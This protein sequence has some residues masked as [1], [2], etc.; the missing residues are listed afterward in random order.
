MGG[1]ETLPSKATRGAG[2]LRLSTGAA[3]HTATHDAAARPISP[4]LPS[5]LRGPRASRGLKPTPRNS[6]AALKRKAEEVL[7]APPGW[8][9]R[10]QREQ[11]PQRQSKSQTRRTKYPAEVLGSKLTGGGCSDRFLTPPRPTL[12][13]GPF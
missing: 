2:R 4:P 1:E 3:R 13:S 5:R 10:R 11:P 7:P 12:P 9:K 8:K 6:A